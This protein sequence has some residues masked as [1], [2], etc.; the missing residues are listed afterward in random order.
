M[1]R[2]VKKWRIISVSILVGIYMVLGL[3]LILSKQ[4]LFHREYLEINLVPLSTLSNYFFNYTN[5]NTK[6][7]ISNILLKMLVFVPIGVFVP[8]IFNKVRNFL[9][10]ITLVFFVSLASELLQLLLRIGFFD[11]DDIILNVLGGAIGLSI[12]KIIGQFTK[13]PSS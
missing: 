3:Q 13:S 6:T 11:V 12:F 2:N 4:H 8:L 10:V 5:F 9:P 1:E 7:L